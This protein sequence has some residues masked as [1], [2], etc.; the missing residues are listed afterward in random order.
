MERK[1][2]N[3]RYFEPVEKV[4]QEFERNSVKIEDIN[5]AEY[6][7]KRLRGELL[8]RLK[9]LA[10][11]TYPEIAKYDLFADVQVHSLGRLYKYAQ[12]RRSMG[13]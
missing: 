4:I 2:Q 10:G 1:R 6:S 12:E 8:V 3:D 13:R 7:A 5:L 11:L 9:D